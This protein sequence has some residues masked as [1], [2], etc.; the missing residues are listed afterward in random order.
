LV[1]GQSAPSEFGW[2]PPHAG[3]S[4]P[5]LAQHRMRSADGTGVA[6][7]EGAAPGTQRP[8][9][10]VCHPVRL[11]PDRPGR[12]QVG[13]LLLQDPCRL[14]ADCV[15]EHREHAQCRCPPR[16]E[17]RRSPWDRSP[18]DSSGFSYCL[19]SDAT[20]DFGP[21]SRCRQANVGASG[22]RDAVAQVGHG[23]RDGF[24]FLDQLGP[25]PGEQPR[26]GSSA[27][28]QPIERSRPLWPPEVMAARCR[29]PFTRLIRAPGP[30]RP[31]ATPSGSSPPTSRRTASRSF[32][33]TPARGRP[34]LHRRPA[35]PL[36]AS[37]R[38]QPLPGPARR[39]RMG[40][41]RG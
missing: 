14:L 26:A 9:G 41:G 3:D 7:H 17:P 34:G 15:D 29:R 5:I 4:Q 12:R 24:P 31:P 32:R 10:V 20:D 23:P 2:W 25:L 6:V 39:L 38:S 37:D 8:S 22:L 27:S 11:G 33:R 21:S 1:P 16:R 18:C 35:G 40:R 36:E 13:A 30:S 19:V 28:L